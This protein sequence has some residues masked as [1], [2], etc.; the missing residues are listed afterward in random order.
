M[1]DSTGTSPYAGTDGASVSPEP[2]APK[3]DSAEKTIQ[4][5]PV[6]HQAKNVADDATGQISSLV[7]R[8]KDKASAAIEGTKSRLADQ[9]DELAGMVQNAGEQFEGQQDWIASAIGGGAA[10][11]SSVARSLREDDLGTLL[12]QVHGFA[13]Q[14]PV[15]F[16]GASFGAGFALSRLGQIAATDISSDDL[17]SVRETYHGER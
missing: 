3:S 17:P 12:R 14:Q 13:R 1:Q 6:V 4:D 7:N 15:L 2:T 11:L 10:G 8:A 9:L 5:S 16:I